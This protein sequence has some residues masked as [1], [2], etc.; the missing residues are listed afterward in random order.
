MKGYEKEF[1]YREK[2]KG[3]GV[4]IFYKKWLTPYTTVLNCCADSMIWLKIDKNVCLNGLDLYICAIYIP[5]DKNV[6]YRKYDIDVFDILQENIEHYSTLGTVAVIGDLNG[7]VGLKADNIVN[8]TLDKE[9]INSI[10]F[11]DYVNDSYICNRKSEDIKPPNSFGQRILQLCQ[12]SGLRICNGRFGTDSGK[13]T[14]NNKNGSS[15]IDYLLFTQSEMFKC[16]KSFY[17]EPFNMYSCHAPIVVELYLKGNNQSYGQCHCN[18]TKFNIFNWN[19]GS[20][21][22]IRSKLILNTQKF[23]DLLVNF[24]ENSDIDTCVERLNNLLTDIYEQY[25]KS[26]VTYKEQCEF[27]ENGD[28]VYKSNADKPW[29]TDECKTLYIQYQNALDSFNKYRSDE[30]RINFNLSKQKY[31]CCETRLKRHYKNQRGNMLS[32]LRKKN[33][34]RFYKNFKKR[35]KRIKNNISLDQF[36]EHFKKLMSKPPEVNVGTSDTPETVFEELDLP[37]TEKELDSC[38]K[39]L[40]RDKSTGYDDI[41]NEYILFGKTLLKP[42]LC[43]LFNNILCA[44][45]FS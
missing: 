43:K 32:S 41:M 12:S 7:R 1:V 28:K 13:I 21:D 3:G 4:V 22:D 37:F 33:P 10:S 11:I 42:V 8:D 15:V 24:D 14:F 34:K 2:C 20:E 29:F 30:N 18:K 36:E 45:N 19:E 40:K 27:C 9:L 26:E 35:K 25:T 38:I 16:L 17:V 6:F 23:D 44:G 39:K 5:P 31:K